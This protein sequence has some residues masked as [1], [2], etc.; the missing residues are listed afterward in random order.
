MSWK[1]L[2]DQWQ[3]TAVTPLPASAVQDTLRRAQ[4]LRRRILWRDGTETVVA[5]A[6]VPT[7]FGWLH[8]A[9]HA[10]IW[11]TEA[12]AALLLVWLFYVPWRLWRA[13]RLLPRND[14]GLPPQ[15]Y[16]ER[17]K[18]AML[19]QARM[20]EQVVWW[21]I[22]PCMLGIAGVTVGNHGL[23][24]G[25]VIYL[26]V[27]LVLCVLIERLNKRAAKHN[28]R[29]R[30]AEIDATCSELATLEAAQEAAHSSKGNHHEP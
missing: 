3:R 18:Q 14:P 9:M 20:L 4:R 28:F 5:L 6:L 8:D 25:V 17:E 10:H 21:Y 7:V 30:V 1:D 29:R 24:R 16:L 27:V 26:A 23:T 11:L 15:R 2:Q 13:R 19:A 12:S 22:A